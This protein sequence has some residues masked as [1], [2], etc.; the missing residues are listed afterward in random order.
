MDEIRDKYL[1]YEPSEEAGNIIDDVEGQPGLNDITDLFFYNEK[2]LDN[3]KREYMVVEL[4]AP[5]CKL[6][7]K[8]LNQIDRYAFTIEDYPS[9]PNENV[10]YKLILISTDVTR[11]AK[12]KLSSARAS[13]PNHPFLYD[14]K[15]DG[16]KHIEVYVMTWSEIIEANKRKLSY[17]ANGLKTLDEDVKEKFERE[18]PQI[19]NEKVSST[20]RKTKSSY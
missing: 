6:S 18:Y 10:V 14:L 5:K 19:L 1:A 16:G 20:L 4:K 12:S 11:F 9:L 8:E 17:L 7:Q 13:H 3:G 2:V 15:E